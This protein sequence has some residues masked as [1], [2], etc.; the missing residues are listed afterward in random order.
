MYPEVVL[1]VNPEGNVPL[2]AEKVYGV[3]PPLTCITSE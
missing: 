1:S 2:V 3:V